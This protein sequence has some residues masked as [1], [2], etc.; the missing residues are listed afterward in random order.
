MHYRNNGWFYP[1]LYFS[2]FDLNYVDEE[3]LEEMSKVFPERLNLIN[4]FDCGLKYDD[5]SIDKC[6]P[7]NPTDDFWCSFPIRDLEK[8]RKAKPVH[9]PK[10]DSAKFFVFLFWLFSPYRYFI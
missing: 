3:I 2:Q 5:I 8:W 4:P 10:L 1:S 9:I 6:P 7:A